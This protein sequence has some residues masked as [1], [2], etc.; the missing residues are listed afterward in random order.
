MQLA[1]AQRKSCAMEKGISCVNPWLHSVDKINIA[2]LAVTSN[3]DFLF[4]RPILVSINTSL[5]QLCFIGLYFSGLFFFPVLEG[6]SGLF[7]WGLCGVVFVLFR[8]VYLGF[9]LLLFV[10]FCLLGVLLWFCLVDLLV[11]VGFFSNL[12][13]AK[14]VYWPGDLFPEKPNRVGR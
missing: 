5:Q 2:Y 9:F 8:L 13:L 4:C 7:V 3:E 11:L 10:A 12:L 6:F 14:F 1:A